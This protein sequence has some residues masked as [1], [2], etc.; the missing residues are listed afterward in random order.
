MSENQILCNILEELKNIKAIHETREKRDTDIVFITIPEN[1]GT[2]EFQIG[3]TKIDFRVGTIVNPDG[4][5]EYLQTKLNAY[6]LKW[7]HS[8]S[9]DANEDIVIKLDGKP[10]RT[11]SANFSTQ[12]PYLTYSSLEITC[13]VLT[14]IQI[15]ACTNPAAVIGQFKVTTVNILE[16]ESINGD[17]TEAQTWDSVVNL[18]NNLNRIR[19]KLNDIIGG[20]LWSDTVSAS[21]STIW[22]QINSHLSATASVHGVGTSG[23]EDKANKNAA[24]G[25]AGLNAAAELTALDA[26]SQKYLSINLA[27]GG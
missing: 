22:A 26:I 14:N 4:S 23:F 27:F 1:G 25:Y 12:I 21:L 11:V 7:L 10:K 24:S 20:T 17:G 5:K 13:T 2:R 3:T 6:Q 16:Q 18:K 9:F 19:K 8:V 15:F